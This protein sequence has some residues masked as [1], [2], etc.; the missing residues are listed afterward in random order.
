MVAFLAFGG[1]SDRNC[2]LC[3]R[4][5]LWDIS[6]IGEIREVAEENIEQYLAECEE[7]EDP[8][9]AAGNPLMQLLMGGP[10]PTESTSKK[11]I[12]GDDND[13]EEDSFGSASKSK[14]RRSKHLQ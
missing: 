2:E 3:L 13:D 5:E 1:I 7:M 6:R 12:I 14:L 8:N 4:K 10:S 11:A 9:A